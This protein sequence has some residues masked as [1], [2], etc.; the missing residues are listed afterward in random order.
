MVQISPIFLVLF[1]SIQLLR[2]FHSSHIVKPGRSSHSL[3]TNLF[4][5]TFIGNFTIVA[6][7]LPLCL[8]FFLKVVT[9]FSHMDSTIGHSF[10]RWLIDSF[11][12]SHMQHLEVPLIPMVYMLSQV[13]MHHLRT[14]QQKST[15]F[16]HQPPPQ[17]SPHLALG[18]RF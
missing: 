13:R 8:W 2:V 5:N 1:S 12:S 17:I 18:S 16:G 14:T 15:T 3:L 4:L 10:R 9:P 11:F 7:G 6:S